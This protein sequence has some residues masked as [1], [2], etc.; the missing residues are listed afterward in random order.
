MDTFLDEMRNQF[1]QGGGGNVIPQSLLFQ[2]TRLMEK[3]VQVLE[4]NQ[5][6]MT[7]VINNVLN[8]GASGPGSA[9]NLRQ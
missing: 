6:S 4:S 9:Q 5:K 7:E 2:Q 3:Q 8:Q 1:T